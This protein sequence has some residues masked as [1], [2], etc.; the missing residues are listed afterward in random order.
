MTMYV[1]LLSRI[2]ILMLV[3]LWLEYVPL[4]CSSSEHISIQ[5]LC[6][7]I[8]AS[9]IVLLYRYLCLHYDTVLDTNK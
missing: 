8:R 4:L 9:L 1:L 7:C 6:P 3:S 2:L 5:Y